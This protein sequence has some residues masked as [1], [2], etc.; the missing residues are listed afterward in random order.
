MIAGCCYGVNFDPTQ[1][2]IDNNPDASQNAVDYIFP[3][4]SGILLTSS[5]YFIVYGLLM[6]NK[7][8]I[9]SEVTIPSIISGIIWAIGM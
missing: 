5:T 4:F 3:H 6:R 8:Q 9:Y 2:Y 1:S 7:P